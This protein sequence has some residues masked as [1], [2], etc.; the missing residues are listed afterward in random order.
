LPAPASRVL[1]LNS[2]ATTSWLINLF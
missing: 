2:C 1:G